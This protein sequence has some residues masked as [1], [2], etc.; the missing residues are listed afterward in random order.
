MELLDAVLADT[1]DGQVEPL[2][3]THGHRQRTRGTERRGGARASMLMMMMLMML[4]LVV[5]VPTIRRTE[6]HVGRPSGT[7]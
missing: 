3:T 2:T 1:D 6:C 7:L 5:V 4:C